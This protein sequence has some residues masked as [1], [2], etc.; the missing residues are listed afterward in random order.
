MFGLFNINKPVGLT[1]HDVVFRVRKQLP[2][3]V[4]VG[5]AGTLDPF[6]SGVLVLFAGSATRL[7]SYVQQ[8]PKRYTAGITLGAFTESDDTET[9]PT[10][11]IGAKAPDRAEVLAV[12]KGFVGEIMQRPPAHSA[13]S[14]GGQRAYKL[15]RQ[16]KTVELAQ[17]PVQIYDINM[18]QYDY[19][20]LKV[21]VSCGSGAYLR[22][23]ARDIGSVLKVGG[24][25]SSLVRTAVGGFAIED[26]VDIQAFQ[27]DKHLIDALRAVEDLP[28][29]QLDDEQ[30]GNIILGRRV[31]HP[32]APCAKESALVDAAGKLVAIASI[33]DDAVVQPTIVLRK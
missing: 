31:H 24:Y 12:L 28:V 4:K 14:I 9:A 7:A 10:A 21:E 32:A 25:C 23:L 11:V 22:S 2:K 17:R 5:H 8:K 29:V 26:A 15:A 20:L 3:G 33:S 30:V 18:L 27:P 1:S 6:A 19:P 16:G 13:I